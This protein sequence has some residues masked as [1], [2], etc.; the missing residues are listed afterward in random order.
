M[1]ALSHPI[2]PFC[3]SCVLSVTGHS[4]T[5]YEYE[6][7]K[8]HKTWSEVRVNGP[9]APERAAAQPEFPRRTA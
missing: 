5:L 9:G 3:L 7:Q 1:R 2:C 4:D 6:C 8:C